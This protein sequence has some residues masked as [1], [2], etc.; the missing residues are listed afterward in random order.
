MTNTTA[1]ESWGAAR[2][3]GGLEDAEHPVDERDIIGGESGEHEGAEDEMP[4]AE[5]VEEMES[6]AP[7]DA[8]AARHAAKKKKD[9]RT[10]MVA[11]VATGVLVV[12]FVGFTAM[13][14]RAA[15]QDGPPQIPLQEAPSQ[16]NQPVN[17][18]APLAASTMRADAPGA[19][20]TENAD[21]SA[22]DALATSSPVPD[23][24]LQAGTVAPMVSVPTAVAPAPAVPVT[25]APTANATATAQMA[26]ASSATLSSGSPQLV[27]GAVVAVAPSQPVTLASATPA[28]AAELEKLRS[29]VASLRGELS[30]KTRALDTATAEIES[31]KR[32]QTSRPAPVRVAV[33]R[34]AAVV[35]PDAAPKTTPFNGITETV[36]VVPPAAAV[37]AVAKAKS[38][39]SDYRVYAVVDGR[40]WVM[41]TDGETAQVAARTPLADGSRVTNVDTEKN[42]VYTT[43]GEIR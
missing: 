1:L 16:A 2:N 30:V 21:G 7:V 42:I 18:E 33:A 4:S 22:S 32:A 6:D 14:G 5:S 3:A 12:G 35:K 41:G 24:G 8:E 25:A 37:P 26:A 34:Q 38:L 17:G 43:T 40:V 13:K 19:I 20:I 36:A 28:G 39:R 27:R 29:E 9:L 11:G 10:L 15:Q 23:F 31:M